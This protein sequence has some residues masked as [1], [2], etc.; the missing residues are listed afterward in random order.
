MCTGP[1]PSSTQKQQAIAHNACVTHL[2]MHADNPSRCVHLALPFCT[3]F[4]GSTVRMHH[5][6]WIQPPDGGH[7]DFSIFILVD[8]L[9]RTSLC[10][11]ANLSVRSNPTHGPPEI[12]GMDILNFDRCQ[13]IAFPLRKII[14]IYIPTIRTIISLP[15]LVNPIDQKMLGSGRFQY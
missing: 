3:G 4:R 12:K 5:N 7:L 10:T 15:F 11:H 8:I 13:Q 1:C 9:V 6:R 14:P 2:V